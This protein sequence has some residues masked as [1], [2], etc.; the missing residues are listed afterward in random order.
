MFGLFHHFSCFQ[1]EHPCLTSTSN[2]RESTSSSKRFHFFL[3]FLPS[4][5]DLGRRSL[6]SVNVLGWNVSSAGIGHFR[7]VQK[8]PSR[9][10][11]P[12]S[13]HS[14]LHTQDWQSYYII[15]IIFTIYVSFCQAWLFCCKLFFKFY[16]FKPYHKEA[17]CVL[18]SSLLHLFWFLNLWFLFYFFK[19]L[20][21]CSL[22]KLTG[23]LILSHIPGVRIKHFIFIK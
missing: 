7:N 10:F 8:S 4:T 19:Y 3:S 12:W 1:T 16:I 18:F 23:Q 6:W 14:D 22:L 9:L 5:C 11:V 13:L 2:S 20:E 15:D 21:A 17:T